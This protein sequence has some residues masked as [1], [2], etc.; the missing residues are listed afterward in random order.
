MLSHY[1]SI[2]G[3][4]KNGNLL[5]S[6]NQIYLTSSTLAIVARHE[7]RVDVSPKL[8]VTADERSARVSSMNFFT[9]IRSGILIEYSF[10]NKT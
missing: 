3:Q 1:R 2:Q 4:S 6:K 5:T 9:V 8:D 10:Q 7:L